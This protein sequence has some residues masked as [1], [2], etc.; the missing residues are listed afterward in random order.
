LEQ[1]KQTLIILLLIGGFVAVLTYFFYHTG[2][3][4]TVPEP[5]AAAEVES[6][7]PLRISP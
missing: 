1:V 4:W 2:E 6:P 3:N 5:N 7:L